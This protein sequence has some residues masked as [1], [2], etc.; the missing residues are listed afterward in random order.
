[1]KIKYNEHKQNRQTQ[2]T[3]W[4]T[5]IILFLVEGEKVL[6][7]VYINDILFVYHYVW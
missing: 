1:M 7:P 3:C 2:T 6:I 5:L 4:I